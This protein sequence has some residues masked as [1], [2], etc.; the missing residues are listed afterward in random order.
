MQSPESKKASVSYAWKPEG[1][2]EGYVAKL[3][4]NRNFGFINILTKDPLSESWRNP[5]PKNIFFHESELRGYPFNQ[6]VIGDRVHFV[7]GQNEKGY[8]AQQIGVQGYGK[9]PLVVVSQ[10]KIFVWLEKVLLFSISS[11]LNI[12]VSFQAGFPSSPPLN[13]PRLFPGSHFLP[14]QPNIGQFSPMHYSPTRSQPN[15]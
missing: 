15:P 11:R 3:D 14:D 6:L 5:Y 9:A 13:D 8:L 12:S 2:Q 10:V 1:I 7:V 4:I